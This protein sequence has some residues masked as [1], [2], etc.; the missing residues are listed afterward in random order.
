MKTAKKVAIIFAISLI[1]AGIALF[2]AGFAMMN[3]NFKEMSPMKYTTNTHKI[4]QE[5]SS[6]NIDIAVA[7]I[8]FIV[9]DSGESRV[10]C[11][12]TEKR[13]HT[14]AVEGDTLTIR[15]HKNFNIFDY[16]N[17]DFNT[18]RVTLYLSRTQLDALNINSDT[19]LI[20]VPSEFSFANCNITNSTGDVK[21]QA[22]TAGELAIKVT[23]GRIMVSDISP[24]SISL[25]ANTGHVTL[26]SAKVSG[27]VCI[28]TSTGRIYLR[29]I[30]CQDLSVTSST[31]NKDI[32]GIRCRNLN[33]A[34][35]T[36]RSIFEDVIAGGV[37]KAEA[38]TGDI[39]LERCD[40]IELFIETDT[41]D[42]EGTLLSDKIF[43]TQTDT[44]KV[45]VPRSV[46]G[47]RCEIETDT[48]DIIMSIVK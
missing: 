44:G 23:T 33:T 13:Y 39:K 12:E 7:D 48:G 15:E 47:G 40:A 37:I 10:E 38:D 22:P 34:S 30:E 9:S 17:F 4:T 46:T 31:G 28:A 26:T 3:F 35:S 14:V 5:F 32:A 42:V 27:N 20:V 29:D 36:G 2:A 11:Y 16:I 6:I 45:N 8:A 25:T 43:F 41:G 1:A 24:K 18:P 21:Y 19:S